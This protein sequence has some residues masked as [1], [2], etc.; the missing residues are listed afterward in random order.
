MVGPGTGVAPFRSILAFRAQKDFYFAD[1][2]HTLTD[3]RIITAFS[4]DQQ[5]K[6]QCHK[7]YG[8]LFI[9]GKAG[10]MPLEVTTCIEKIVNEN[11][12]NGKQFIQM[13]ETKGRLQY[14]TWN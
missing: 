8:Y 10:D 9:A 12:E 5:N 7:Y 14:E 3:A 1:E 13:L 6:Y 4:R 2:W 11:G